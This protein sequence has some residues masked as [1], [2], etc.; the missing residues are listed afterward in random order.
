MLRI[1]AMCPEDLSAAMRLSQEA[2]W[3]QVEA[4]WRRFLSMEPEGC[5]VAESGGVVIGTTVSCTFGTIAWLAMVL[6]ARAERG[7]GVATRL[8]RHAV[9]WLEGRGV[10]TIRLDATPAGQ[11]IYE[12]L[13]FDA[14]YELAR[15]EGELALLERD[16][17]AEPAS[18]D[19]LSK[20]LEL[21]Q[22]VTRTARAKWLTALFTAWPEA[23]RV[24]RREGEI[25]GFAA[26]RRGAQA[27]QVGPCVGNAEA[28]PLLLH[29]AGRR[30]DGQAVYLDVP[31]LNPAA[32]QEAEAHG[33]AHP[34]APGTDVP[35]RAGV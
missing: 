25:L 32:A 26:A 8:T 23:V 27:V 11:R 10:R 3:N 24:V 17:G 1:R 28:G 7:R 14:Q 4:D 13:G 31:L 16:S 21:D 9:E 19:E 2:G 30:Y 35:G 18:P 6:V 5:F 34:A 12:K 33:P 15:Y 20:L 29:D 22:R